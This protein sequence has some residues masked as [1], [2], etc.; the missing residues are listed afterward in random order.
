ML[1]YVRKHQGFRTSYANPIVARVNQLKSA[2]EQVTTTI[3][4]DQLAHSLA[5][6]DEA[7]RQRSA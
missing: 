3:N 5:A 6:A 4:L 2:Y 7:A 1:G